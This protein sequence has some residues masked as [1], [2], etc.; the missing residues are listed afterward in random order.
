M[1]SD[2]ACGSGGG[3]CCPAWWW[4]VDSNHRTRKRA[5]LQSA[6][7]NHFATPPEAADRRG[8]NPTTAKRRAIL[9][10]QGRMSSPPGQAVVH[11]S[12]AMR[13]IVHR[14]RRRSVRRGKA[15][16]PSGCETRPA[17]VAPA[18]SSWSRGVETE[19]WD[20]LRH[21][22]R[23]KAAG[24]GYSPTLPPPR[25]PLTLPS[26]GKGRAGRRLRRRLRLTTEQ[27]RAGRGASPRDRCRQSTPAA[28]PQR[29]RS[30]RCTGGPVGRPSVQ[31]DLRDRCSPPTPAPPLQRGG[32]TAFASP[33]T[34]RTAP[35][36]S[37]VAGLRPL[38]PHSISRHPF[39]SERAARRSAG[40]GYPPPGNATLQR[41]TV[42]V[43]EVLVPM[44]G[45]AG[46]WRS[47]GHASLYVVTP[48]SRSPG[49]A[50]PAAPRRPGA[51]PHAE[52]RGKAR[53]R[54]C[55]ARAGVDTGAGP[56]C[57]RRRTARAE[58]E[59]DGA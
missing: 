40:G 47:R 39:G 25:R 35:T 34:A 5:D 55:A 50:R 2:F 15:T 19:L 3:G 7:F 36:E 27:A 24:H 45:Q 16:P 13:P 17:T 8:A 37:G 30:P 26:A 38:P 9:A 6:A 52:N 53:L 59:G 22:H 32:D 21:R 4:G 33:A 48:S 41:G 51:P 12:S 46:A 11:S 49:A 29:V 58:R 23:A 31:R 54:P 1:D 43:R 20:G 57:A 42:M 18:G 10:D 14:S 28:F 56:R 44:I